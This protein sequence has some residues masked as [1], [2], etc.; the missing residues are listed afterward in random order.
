MKPLRLCL[1]VMLAA[2]AGSAHATA[3]RIWGLEAYGDVCPISFSQQSAGQG[4]SRVIQRAV[5]CRGG[6]SNIAA[7]SAESG[8]ATYFFHDRSGQILG[9]VDDVGGGRY[10]GAWGDGDALSMAYLGTAGGG[11]SSSAGKTSSGSSE[12]QSC[13]VYVQTDICAEAYDIGVPDASRMEPLARMNLR[14]SS[15]LTSQVTGKV[16]RGQCLE[17]YRCRDEPFATDRLW[18][19]V[20]LEGQTGWVLMQ[21]ESYVYTRNDCD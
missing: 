9:R 16:D 11:A 18:C 8:G 13:R 3:E 1:T 21:D 4:L 19:E 10:E 5:S 17:V 6:L 20:Q 7:W 15:S 2:F 12:A 14:F